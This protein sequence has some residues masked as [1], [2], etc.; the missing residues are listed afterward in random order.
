MRNAPHFIDKIHRGQTCYGCAI[1]SM[2]PVL[3]EAMAAV[4]DALWIDAEHGPL[5]IETVQALVMAVHTT[6]SAAFVRVA[7]N[8]PV[9][10]KPILDLGADGIIVPMIRSAEEARAAVAACRYPPH[11]VRG[12]GPRRASRFGHYGSGPDYVERA[13]ADALCM[14]QIEHIDAVRCIDSILAV[15]GLGGILIGANDLSFSMG[16]PSQPDH[17]EVR[18]AIEQVLAAAAGSDVFVGMAMGGDV[19]SAG[20]WI[21]LGVRWMVMETETSLMLR[22]AH[23]L[24]GAIRS[25]MHAA[26]TEVAVPRSQTS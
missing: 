19:E 3:T 24:F 8:D 12:F 9:L 7:W 13:N 5:S 25:R 2:D 21:D 15:E 10:I 26:G 16:F 20:R 6:D 4:V 23:E 14:V 22:A 1:T 17:P 18:R 11:G